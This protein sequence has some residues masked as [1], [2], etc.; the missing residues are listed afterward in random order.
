MAADSVNGDTEATTNTPPSPSPSPTLADSDKTPSP[1][2]EI[3]YVDSKYSEDPKGW[4]YEDTSNPAGVPAELVQP[5]GM[6]TSGDDSWDEFCF[7]VVRRHPKPKENNEGTRQIAFE[8]VVKSPYLL[9]ACKEVMTHVRGI[10]WNSPP[11]TVS[12]SCLRS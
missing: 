1:K 6:D 8:I 10:S 9:K 12:P 3:K 11:V 2:L 4:Q 7:V 5:V